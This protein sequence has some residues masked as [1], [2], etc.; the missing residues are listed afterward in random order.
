MQ[1]SKYGSWSSSRSK[2]RTKLTRLFGI[3]TRGPADSWERWCARVRAS[4]WASATPR[5]LAAELLVP[6]AGSALAQTLPHTCSPVHANLLSYPTPFLYLIL[7]THDSCYSR[8]YSWDK[9]CICIETPNPFSV[10]LDNL[11]GGG[12]GWI[13]GMFE[14]SYVINY[15]GP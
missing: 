10:V 11:W 3:R 1:Q 12:G 4:G 14:R 13:W 8:M 9:S 5:R 7:L 15:N 6:G 2:M